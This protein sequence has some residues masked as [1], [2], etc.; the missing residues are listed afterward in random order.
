MVPF[1]YGLPKA[2]LHLHLEGS[3]EP[4]MMLALSER[5]RVALPYRSAADIRKAFAFG[6]LQAFLDIYYAGMSVLCKPRDFYELTFAYLKKAAS[7]GVIHAEMFFD[8]QAHREKGLAFADLLDPIEQACAEAERSMGVSTR[9]IPCFLRDRPLAEA[10]AL[11]REMEPHAHRIAAVGLDSQEVGYPP[12]LFSRIFAD[13][14]DAGLKVVAHA[15]EEGPPEYV[16]EALDLLHAARIDHGVRSIEDPELT[17]RL[18]KEKIP[19][20]VCPYSNWKLGVFPSLQQHNLP[21]LIEAGLMVTVHSDDP[22][23]LGAYIGENF[24]ACQN[25]MGLPAAI[26]VQLARNS[27]EA[28]FLDEASK[29]RCQEKIDAYGKTNS[30]A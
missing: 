10:R 8:P 7:Q 30:A 11:W 2:E 18:V 1:P 13:V 4:E 5:N 27:F 22:A 9:L 28:S 12:G 26:L 3:L 24:Q 14:R 23:Y 16:R 25:E 17:Q 6:S 15:G 21:K 19:L 29:R 20:T